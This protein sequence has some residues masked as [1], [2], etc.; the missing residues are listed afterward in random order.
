VLATNIFFPI[1]L[2]FTDGLSK[3]EKASKKEIE[4]D[5][6]IEWNLFDLQKHQSA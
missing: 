3:N 2:Q 4:H 5:Q 1:K 6:I